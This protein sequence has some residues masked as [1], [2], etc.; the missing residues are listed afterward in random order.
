MRAKQKLLLVLVVLL[1]ACRGGQ[2]EPLE[3]AARPE[4]LDLVSSDIPE[5]LDGFFIDL[6]FRSQP[7]SEPEEQELIPGEPVLDQVRDKARISDSMLEKYPSIP[8]LVRQL[9]LEGSGAPVLLGSRASAMFQVLEL[10]GFTHEF[11]YLPSE[12]GLDLVQE[13]SRDLCRWTACREDA[14]CP[15]SLA[16]PLSTRLGV[17][18]QPLVRFNCDPA[19]LDDPGLVE[20]LEPVLVLALTKFME[21]FA[22]EEASDGFLVGLMSA[23]DPIA[24][25]MEILPRSSRFWHKVQA[26][27]NLA[28]YGVR[29]DMPVMG[30]WGELGPGAKGPR[31][32]RLRRRLVA[33]GYLAPEFKEGQGFDKTLRE[34]ILDYRR[35]HGMRVRPRVDKRMMK[36]LSVSADSLIIHLQQ[37]LRTSIEKGWDRHDDY[38]LVNIPAAMTHLYVAGERDS[39]YVSVVGF[40]Y[41]EPGGRTPE[42]DEE[43]TYV[44]VNPD[45]TP[46]PYVLDN[47][48]GPKAKK[49]PGFWAANHFVMRAGKRVQEPGPWN[50]LG[51]V[52][53]AFENENNIYLH[54]S[55]DTE[56]FGFAERALSHGCVRVQG[57]E[58]LARRLLDL[59][60]QDVNEFDEKLRKVV[61]RRYEP[62]NDFPVHFA[63]DLVQVTDKGQVA[64]SRDIYKLLPDRTRASLPGLTLFKDLVA[65][66]TGRDPGA[67]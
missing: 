54:G 7:E 41:L 65:R 16:D 51:Q 34:S 37:S 38:L 31:V 5:V 25:I 60:N 32:G 10:L 44:E 18:Q 47:E 48:L 59:G 20:E 14:P 56:K 13:A 15:G 63:Y 1:A 3:D 52:V 33:E 35:A 27:R 12:L 58:A 21:I 26:L 24:R 2:E 40:P 53:I 19:L 30:G 66:A 22:R 67:K 28:W 62:G 61:P 46:T 45:W 8:P 39:S 49:D 42:F 11:G 17:S 64:L 4:E 29:G 55:P 57:I 23:E 9:Y 36:A 50:T 43:I 6:T